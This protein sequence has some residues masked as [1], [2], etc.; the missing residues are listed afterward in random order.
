[1]STLTTFYNY[2][3]GNESEFVF[4]CKGRPFTSLISTF[5]PTPSSTLIDYGLVK[6]LNFKMTDL[7]C[8]KFHY[9]GYKMRILGHVTTAVQTIKNGF[10]SGNFQFSAKV[11]L[12]LNKNLD[13]FSI[14]GHKMSKQLSQDLPVAADQ[15]QDD[16]NVPA[17]A[18]SRSPAAPYSDVDVV[19]TPKPKRSPTK[20]NK[21]ASESHPLFHSLHQDHRQQLFLMTPH[22]LQ[23]SIQ[24]PRSCSLHPLH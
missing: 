4:S 22:H 6:D 21:K 20:P 12:D 23:L 24:P 14:A 15:A 8:Q 7:Q 2:S 3:D 17:D 13:T 10:T 11:V 9:G 19:A 1:M 18:P 5:L 16:H